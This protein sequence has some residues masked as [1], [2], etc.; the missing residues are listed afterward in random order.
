MYIYIYEYLNSQQFGKRSQA[1]SKKKRFVLL[2][3]FTTFQFAREEN[4]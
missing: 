4:S 2:E 3:N 1:R